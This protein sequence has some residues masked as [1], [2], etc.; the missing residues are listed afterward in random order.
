MLN[1][2]QDLLLEGEQDMRAVLGFAASAVETEKSSL[3]YRVWGLIKT[4]E[5]SRSNS[6]LSPASQGPSL[7]K[8]LLK[9]IEIRDQAHSCSQIDGCFKKL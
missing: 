4:R 6:H 7:R 8:E 2:V 3:G 5:D 9:R 1:S